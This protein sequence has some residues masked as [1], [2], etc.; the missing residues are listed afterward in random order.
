LFFVLFVFQDRVSPYSPDWLGIHNLP[1]SSSQILG[2][3][4]CTTTLSKLIFFFL[5]TFVWT[6]DLHLETLPQSFFVMGIFQIE[7]HQ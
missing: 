5:Q 3:Q 2:L 6:Q 1:A 4:A 7:T